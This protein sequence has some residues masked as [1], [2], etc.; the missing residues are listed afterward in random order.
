MKNNK[1][2]NEYKTLLSA[3]A[4][5]SPEDSQNLVIKYGGEKAKDYDELEYKLAQIYA[6]TPDKLEI[7]KE[8]A[9]IHPHSK[10]IL[11]YLSPKKEIKPLEPMIEKTI[12]T[13]E[14][15]KLVKSILVHD[16]YENADGESEQIS[17][18]E[19]CNCNCH[20]ISNAD[21]LTT[22]SDSRKINFDSLVLFGIIAIV[23]IV[24]IT[25]NKI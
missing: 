4:Y 15:S 23:G 25:K 19:G 17:N 1:K 7:E 22:T 21:G 9:S 20:K 18:G 12:D 3:L 14:G 2:K 24:A 11:K 5:G 8:F 10:F 13:T 16:G 6:N